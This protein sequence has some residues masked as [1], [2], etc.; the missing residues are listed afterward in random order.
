MYCIVFYCD[1]SDTTGN[2]RTILSV[3]CFPHSAVYWHGGVIAESHLTKMTFE[4]TG[5]YFLNQQIRWIK[6]PVFILFL[7]GAVLT[8][9]LYFIERVFFYFAVRW[10]TLILDD[11]RL[12]RRVRSPVAICLE[13]V[14]FPAPWNGFKW[15]HEKSSDNPRGAR[16]L[17]ANLICKCA[18]MWAMPVFYSP[19]PHNVGNVGV[20][21]AYAGISHVDKERRDLSPSPS[22]SRSGWS[23]FLTW[24]HSSLGIVWRGISNTLKSHNNTWRQMM[25]FFLFLNV[26]FKTKEMLK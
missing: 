4:C 17:L 20:G 14:E 11:V 19:V 13:G 3:C 8:P 10:A 22:A 18:C 25:F 1:N 26:K 23:S 15:R 7:S 2:T 24:R 16:L 21:P 6:F 12:A 9:E 5:H